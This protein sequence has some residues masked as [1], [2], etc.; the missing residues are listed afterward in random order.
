M[1]ALYFVNV[2]C[3]CKI[4]H[5][6]SGAVVTAVLLEFFYCRAYFSFIHLFASDN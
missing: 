1:P 4:I 3:V 5:M 2:V 6:F